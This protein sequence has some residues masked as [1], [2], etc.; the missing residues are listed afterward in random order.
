MPDQPRRQQQTEHK[1]EAANKQPGYREELQHGVMGQSDLAQNI[2]AGHSSQDHPGRQYQLMIE[3]AP[4]PDQIAVADEFESGGQLEKSHDHLHRIHPGTALGQ[5]GQHLGEQGQEEKGQGESDGVGHH[6]DYRPKIMALAGRHQ[7]QSYE[8][9]GAGERGQGKGE[10][11]KENAEG[12]TP[13]FFRQA[14]LAQ[15]GWHL[16]LIQT[17]KTAREVDKQPPQQEVDNWI[18]G[19]LVGPGSP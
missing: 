12:S 4:A 9:D 11:H 16:N 3:E 2:K 10:G 18:G 13:G 8:L 7:Q 19:H 1:E 17:E 5:P 6:T 14:E 15:A